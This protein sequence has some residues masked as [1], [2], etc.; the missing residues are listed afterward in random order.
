VDLIAQTTS[1]APIDR[2][3]GSYGPRVATEDFF[4]LDNRRASVF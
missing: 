4:K 2:Q 3:F 1:V